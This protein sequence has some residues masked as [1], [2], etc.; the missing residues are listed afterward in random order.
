MEPISLSYKSEDSKLSKAWQQQPY[1]SEK[2]SEKSPALQLKEG[3]LIRDGKILTGGRFNPSW[4]RGS[5][6]PKNQQAPHITR[7]AL[8]PEGYRVVDNLDEMTDNMQESG[9]LVIDHN[10]GLWYDRRRDDHERT[11]R[12]DGEVRAPFYELPFA[13]SG[14]GRAWDGLSK[15][16]LTKWN[17]W[18][19]NRLRTYADM[20]D[21]KGLILFHQQYFQHNIIEAGAH[22]VDSPWR[23]ANNV[24][25]TGFPEPGYLMPATRGSLWLNI[26]TI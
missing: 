19:W 1:M 26:F 16:D 7:F 23:S 25:Q 18:Y 13:R 17:N 3:V 12:I 15:Y 4:W 20:A 24:N 5:L 11:S 9:T 6:Q 10:Y 21:Q 8:E 22:W 2:T 14:Q